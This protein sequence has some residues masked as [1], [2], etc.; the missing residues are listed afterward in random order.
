MTFSPGRYGNY[1]YGHTPVYVFASKCVKVNSPTTLKGRSQLDEETLVRDRRN[2]SKR[3]H[4]E[5]IIGCA[6]TFKIMKTTLNSEEASMGGKI[7]SVL[8]ANEF[9]AV[10]RGYNLSLLGVY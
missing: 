6:K 1:Y 7:M 4:V 2:A 9:Q 3:I 10:N 5:R 8:R